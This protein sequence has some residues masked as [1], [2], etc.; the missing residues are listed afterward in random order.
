MTR[1]TKS[2]TAFVVAVSFHDASGGVAGCGR[3]CGTATDVT[4]ARTTTPKEAGASRM[5][6]LTGRRDRSAAE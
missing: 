4:K 2:V 6:D 5:C 1:L 3:M